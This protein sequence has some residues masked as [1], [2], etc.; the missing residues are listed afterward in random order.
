MYFD[1][2]QLK[3]IDIRKLIVYYKLGRP[4]DKF[5]LCPSHEMD[6]NHHNPS[7]AVDYQHNLLFCKSGSCGYCNKPL[8][9]LNIVAIMEKRG[10]RGTDFINNCK[11]LQ[12]IDKAIPDEIEEMSNDDT[13]QQYKKTETTKEPQKQE[14]DSYT[15]YDKNS[16]T[17]SQLHFR[18]DYSLDFY[19]LKRRID[20]YKIYEILDKNHISIKQQTLTN[21]NKEVI[22]RICYIFDNYKKFAVCRKTGDYISNKKYKD[23]NGKTIEVFKFNSKNPTYSFI[24]TDYKNDKILLIFEGI[25]DL[26]SFLTTCNNPDDYDY[27]SLNS[28]T[29]S[30][31]FVS[32]YEYMLDNYSKVICLLDNDD[33]GR[34]TY[35]TIHDGLKNYIVEDLSH[36]YSGFNDVNDYIINKGELK[37]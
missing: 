12:A 8:D 9:N 4:G 29:H 24:R 15:K 14:E 5:V 33:S 21:E 17:I 13:S 31:N 18:N 7:A 2:Q 16:L 36:L 35:K 27:V 3:N 34:E 23:E 1:L 6:G 32:D 19:L 28:T 37:L 26:L 11:R 10:M 25:Y 20:V 22:D 30:K